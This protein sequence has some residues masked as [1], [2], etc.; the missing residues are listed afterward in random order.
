MMVS[1]IVHQNEI[2]IDFL[3]HKGLLFF[4]PSN[5]L[6]YRDTFHDP[7]ISQM[8]KST[9]PIFGL[10]GCPLLLRNRFWTATDNKT[11]LL[12]GLTRLTKTWLCAPELFS[13]QNLLRNPTFYLV[14]PARQYVKCLLAQAENIWTSW[15]NLREPLDKLLSVVCSLQCNY[16]SAYPIIA[17]HVQTFDLPPTPPSNYD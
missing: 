4:N 3:F 12:R 6:S 16:A 13:C 7:L 11:Y 8:Q 2:W 14:L 5:L 1:I 15:N 9:H 10:L 17:F